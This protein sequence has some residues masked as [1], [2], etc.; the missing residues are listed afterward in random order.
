[1]YPTRK[2]FNYQGKLNLEML[3][4]QNVQYKRNL[5]RPNLKP[6]ITGWTCISKRLLTI[7]QTKIRLIYPHWWLRHGFM[8]NS[9]RIGKSCLEVSFFWVPIFW[10][11]I[12]VFI[13]VTFPKTFLSP[14]TSNWTCKYIFLSII[15]QWKYLLTKILCALTI[16][17]FMIFS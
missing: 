10:S 13:F 8:R 6:L 14:I 15:S 9:W 4:N 7:C 1:M 5:Q 3:Q 16:S 12:S 11:P 2:L 17:I